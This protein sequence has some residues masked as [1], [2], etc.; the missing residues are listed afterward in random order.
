MLVNTWG[1]AWIPFHKLHLSVFWSSIVGRGF[2]SL[3]TVVGIFFLCP[4]ALKR[5]RFNWNLKQSGISLLVVA[6][7]MAPQLIHTNFHG[8]GIAQF[9]EAF[10][11][12][13][14]IGIE[15]DFFARGFI[16]GALERYGVW[17][18]ALVSSG[19]F[20][21]SHLTNILWGHQSAAFT[22]AQAVNAGAFG[23][24]AVGLMLYSG[25]IWVPILMHGLA[26][27]PMQFDTQTQYVKMV[28]GQGDWVGVGLDCL[29]YGVI[30]WILISRA[31]LNSRVRQAT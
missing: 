14:F 16:Y 28:T 7:L 26:D 13:I 24:L 6:Y 27:L 2:S 21:L 18:A 1:L 25:S 30:G 19:L 31:N 11:F 20:G 5:F 15:E 8:T 22:I 29:I 3:V 9:I 4:S 17:F 23:F 12:S 10:V